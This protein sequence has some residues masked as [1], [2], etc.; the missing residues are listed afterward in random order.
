[1]LTGNLPGNGG[2]TRA[3]DVAPAERIGLQVVARAHGQV[4]DEA[5]LAGLPFLVADLGFEVVVQA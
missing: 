1:M 2:E 5:H 3:R 4:V